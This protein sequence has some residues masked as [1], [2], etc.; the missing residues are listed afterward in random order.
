MIGKLSNG[1]GPFAGIQIILCIAFAAIITVMTASFTATA[2][3]GQ[4]IPVILYHHILDESEN[5]LF[6][7]NPYTV[8]SEM[9]EAQM[10]YLYDNDF[11]ALTADELYSFLYSGTALPQKSVLI[12]FDDGYYSNVTRAY[13]TLKKY[14]FRA[15]IFSITAGAQGRQTPFDPDTLAKISAETMKETADVFSYASHTHNMHDFYDNTEYTVFLAASGEEI[16][17]DLNL[18]FA[19]VDDI[20]SFAYPLGQHNQSKIDILQ[21]AGIKMAFTVNPG[22]VTT[23]CNPFRLNRFTI[24][25]TTTLDTFVRYVSGSAA[26]AANPT[27]GY[28]DF[29]QLQNSTPP[30]IKVTM[31]GENVD[32]DIPPQMDDGR[33]L[34]PVRAIADSAG[35]LVE[36]NGNAETVTVRA[37]GTTLVFKIGESIMTVN[38][39]SVLI[40]CKPVLTEG[41]ALVP[42]R[43]LAEALG[44]T[45]DWDEATQT[46]HI[47]EFT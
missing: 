2:M 38:G 19:L 9:F 47:V 7:D 28:I 22:Y 29:I 42:V 4:R 8:S 16:L 33:I 5:R 46:V 15:S 13:P 32:F 37:D 14:G 11:H 41:R 39:R 40:D 23:Q 17:S 21:E 1:A 24:F 35:A 26:H 3:E 34:V 43:F 6:R 20:I 44:K 27:I 30:G 31:L 45:I 12:H 25:R 18:S 36:W 10:K